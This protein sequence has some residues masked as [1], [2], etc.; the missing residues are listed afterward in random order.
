LWEQPEKMAAGICENVKI[1]KFPHSIR[2]HSQ[3]FKCQWLLSEV[4]PSTH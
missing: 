3:P 4:S 2:K 1:R